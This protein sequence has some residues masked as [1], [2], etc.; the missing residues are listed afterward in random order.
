M[1]RHL[2]VVIGL[3]EIGRPIYQ[4]LSDA[5]GTEEVRG[6]DLFYPDPSSGITR[7]M[8]HTFRY[9]HVCFPQNLDF[10]QQLKDYVRKYS[11]NCVII[12]STLSPGMTSYLDHEFDAIVFY[13]PV[14]G[15]IKD[16]M[17]WSLKKYTKY[18]AGFG[19]DGVDITMV[20][21][22][23]TGANF[24]VTYVEDPWALE[25][26][27]IWDLA[28][29]GLNIAFYQVMERTLDKT[30]VDVTRAFIESTPVESEGKAP[31]TLLYGGFIGGHCVIP[32]IEKILA[33]HDIPMLREVLD[34][35]IRRSLE[36]IHERPEHHP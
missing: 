17:L 12:H 32:A 16:G 26:A 7:A 20:L 1:S 5:Y 2:A 33:E 29:Y 30:T 24:K 11:P 22:H 14:R 25:C 3:G 6:L 31:R 18:V 35:N 36:L 8:E 19:I 9:M 28:W 23:L 21:Q 10:V 34:S 27:K 15:N 13:S 4:M